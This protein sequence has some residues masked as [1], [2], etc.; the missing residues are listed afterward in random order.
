[1]I[2]PK[3]SALS[4]SKTYPAFLLSW[5]VGAVVALLSMSPTRA[6]S[7]PPLAQSP[8]K[9]AIKSAT[10][11]ALVEQAEILAKVEALARRFE[12]R[13]LA[14]DPDSLTRFA[15]DM[16]SKASGMTDKASKIERLARELKDLANDKANK[17]RELEGSDDKRDAESLRDEINSLNATIR[18]AVSELNDIDP[19]QRE[20]NRARGLVAVALGDKALA[21]GSPPS[22][23][24]KA[25]VDAVNEWERVMLA[26]DPKFSNRT[27]ATKI[28]IRQMIADEGMPSSPEKALDQARRAYL[29]VQEKG[30]KP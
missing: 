28:R 20:L 24:N 5:Q 18:Q 23:P 2:H 14:S 16:E 10:P 17:L 22:H 7:P 19:D 26:K 8:R 1:M 11:P 15:R 21:A 27:E 3:I 13:L 30:G 25:I 6:E 4:A 9:E 29:E 12:S